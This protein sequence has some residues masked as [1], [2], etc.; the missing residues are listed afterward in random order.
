MKKLGEKI[1]RLLRDILAP[2]VTY[3]IYSSSKDIKP[4]DWKPI[5]NDFEKVF[6]D[7]NKV[8]ENMNNLFKKL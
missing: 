5:W 2:R 8:F 6:E 7:M 1:K 4:E 3:H